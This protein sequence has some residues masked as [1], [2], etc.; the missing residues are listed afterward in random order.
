MGMNESV[1]Y[2]LRSGG[3]LLI[4]DLFQSE[5]LLDCMVSSLAVPVNIVLR[6][7]KGNR[8]R[9]PR[10]VREAW[11]RHSLYD[12]YLTLRRVRELCDGVLPGARVRRHLLWR[13]SLVWHK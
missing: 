1:I 10:I 12:E 7:A 8:W 3:V 9:V 6:L 13:Y 4:L 5:T 2:A 11:S